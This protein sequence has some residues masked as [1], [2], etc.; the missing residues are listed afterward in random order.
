MT[1]GTYNWYCQY[2]Y[3][4]MWN[5]IRFNNSNRG[6]KIMCSL[7]LPIASKLIMLKLNMHTQLKIQIDR[8]KIPLTSVAILVSDLWNDKCTYLTYNGYDKW[9]TYPRYTY[10]FQSLL[11]LNGN[12]QYTVLRTVISQSHIIITYNLSLLLMGKHT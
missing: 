6:P 1:C 12:T 4:I 9:R 3:K 11:V 7:V 5:I 2:I 10:V 8:R